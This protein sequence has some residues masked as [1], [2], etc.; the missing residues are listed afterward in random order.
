[1]KTYVRLV[2]LALAALLSVA[3]IL[4]TAIHY[5][6]LQYCSGFLDEKS[7]CLS[8]TFQMQSDEVEFPSHDYDTAGRTLTRTNGTRLTQSART[9]FLLK[10]NRFLADS[11]SSCTSF[12]PPTNARLQLRIWLS[13]RLKARADPSAA[14]Y[15]SVA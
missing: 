11:V 3:G 6:E 5:A 1:M 14:Q 10:P 9:I 15:H 8:I 2:F 4:V 7:D 12:A 13:P